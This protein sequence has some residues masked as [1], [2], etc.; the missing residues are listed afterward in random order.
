M[1]NIQ[2]RLF[3]NKKIEKTIK[4]VAFNGNRRVNSKEGN[5]GGPLLD[6]NGII[7][8]YLEQEKLHMEVFKL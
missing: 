1:N 4:I 8:F 6:W 2:R 5:E 7:W 3:A